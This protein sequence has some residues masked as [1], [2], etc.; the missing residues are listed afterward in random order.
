ML[1]GRALNPR[2][3]WAWF[4]GAF[5]CL[6]LLIG[7]VLHAERKE[8]D[9]QES[10]RLK[11]Q[12]HVIAD[13]LGRQL[14]GLSQALSGIREELPSWDPQQLARVA[15]TRLKALSD[16][17]PGV[18]AIHILDAQGQVLATS[19]DI[20]TV[21]RSFADREL[22]T[23][24]RDRADPTLLYLSPPYASRREQ[25]YTVNV[26][27]AL[28]DGSGRF[29][30]VVTAALNPDY[31]QVLLRS[32]LYAPDMQTALL[33]GDGTLFLS[34]P[35]VDRSVGVDRSKPSSFFTRHRDSGNTE[36]LLVGRSSSS[37]D[38]R[39]MVMRTIQ[40]TAPTMDRPLIVAVSR[41]LA[42]VVLPWRRHAI[43]YTTLLLLFASAAGLVL[44]RQ[45]R[46]RAAHE[47]FTLAREAERHDSAE[48]LELALAGADLGLWD[49][50]V[51]SNK[52]VF[53]SRWFTM[54]GYASN[55]F[56][57]VLEVWRSLL[58]PEDSQLAQA[59][60]D[61]HLQGRTV[62]YELEHR[63]RSK[64]G[65]WQWILARGRVVQRAADGAPL[66]MVGTHMDI[67]ARKAAE[68]ALDD[69][70]ALT[71][72]IIDN[73]PHGFTVRDAELRYR[74]WNPMMETLTGVPADRV[75]GRTTDEVFPELA[76]PLYE[77]LVKSLHE[78]LAGQI[79][80]TPD[81]LIARGNKSYWTTAIHGPLRDA[82]GR[83]V[84]T[85]SSV[86]EI[87][88]RKRA[89]QQLRKS[90]GDQAVTLQS[91][92]DAVIATDV[93]GRISRMN[94]C[95]ERLTGW[96]LAAGLGQPLAKVFRIVNAVTRQGVPDPVELVL[97]HGEIIGLDNHTTLLS[98]DGAEYQ[99]ADSAAPIR[100]ATGQITGV[101]L[102][103][104]D[105]SQAYRVQEALKESERRFRAIFDASPE[106][107]K[108][109]DTKGRIIEINAAGLVVFEAGSLQALQ[110]Q[111]LRD[112]V[113]PE[114]RRGVD[115]QL[116]QTL[117]GFGGVIEFE[118]VG[119]Q[120]TRRWLESHAA[121]L[122][123]TAGQMTMLVIARDITL[124]KQG[125][126][127]RRAL[128][129]KL[130]ETQ[131]IEAIGTLASGIAHDFNNILG[132]IAGNTALALQD[133][134]PEHPAA[135]SLGQINKASQRARDMV[136]QILTFSRGQ[137]PD[138]ATQALQPLLTEAMSLLRST[139]PAMVELQA[140]F[141][142]QPLYVNA[143]ATQIAQVLMNLC[144]NAWHAMQGGTGRIVVGLQAVVFDADSAQRLRAPC[145]GPH[146]HLWV[147]DTGAG[148]D[149]ATRLRIFEP[150]FSTKPK[151]LGTGLGL[152]VVHGIVGTHNGVIV[153]DSVLGQGSTFHVYLPLV[154][155]PS[156]LQPAAI[157]APTA[158]P[159]DGQHVLYVDDDE[160][161]ALMAERLLQ[162]AGFR[163]TCLLSP[164]DAIAAVRV[165]PGS[166]DLVVTDYNMPQHSGLDV[167]LALKDIRADLPVII[168]SGNLTDELRAGALRLGVKHLLQKQ[169]TVDDLCAMVHD[170]L[171]G[172]SG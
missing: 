115:T 26:G 46:R 106:C 167:A 157:A 162:R 113:L 102:V 107:I 43:L 40:R 16:A 21:G 82:Q 93:A 35:A 78:A 145:A 169:N 28:S 96:P 155:P 37:G 12:A 161:M 104:S 71:Q 53:S 19:S 111:G 137:S 86:Q 144:T 34:V 110:Q 29:A 6:A 91:I 142:E 74:R 136:R 1:T 109:V 4:V 103:F 101:V 108:I 48:R 165:R 50:H 149:A 25:I 69:S 170:V 65:Q 9:A 57:P 30:G 87:T 73:L 121:A 90:E 18:Q 49:W 143:D 99:I 89:E 56:E 5:A 33:H 132:A 68:A 135:L 159:G 114:Y 100:D 2:R 134:G 98:R 31:F 127:E 8:M 61:A 51:P 23:L 77:A 44:A 154:E 52:V 124:R 122:Q 112:L 128:Q 79:V 27:R 39:V 66:R 148:I 59:T 168:S 139:L 41:D 72:Q 141:A 158:T 97:T 83:I 13:N 156:D 85:I 126:A 60:I 15:G 55:D 152:S 94:G 92:G 150:F 20:A 75:I 166:F 171:S 140:Q 22:F 3:E 76:G 24:P 10:D 146:A 32:V 125:Q 95:A 151:G 14:E 42:A 11:V 63:L 54:L 70:H 81:R 133:V 47:R 119:L 160:V 36:S 62:L 7:F 163:V 138:L 131:R 153:V 172:R 105:V 116:R 67:T 123:D 118:I 17:M 164:A 88:D 129:E 38:E 84:G 117:A 80:V 130:R 120:G 64:S 147:S 58:H 45:Q